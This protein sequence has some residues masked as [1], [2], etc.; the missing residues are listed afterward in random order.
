MSGLTRPSTLRAYLVAHE[1]RGD[2]RADWRPQAG[3]GVPAGPSGKRAI[4]PASDVVEGAVDLCDLRIQERGQRA[5]PLA[6]DLVDARS[7]ASPKRSDSA[8]AADHG[9]LPI[10]VDVVTGDRVGI[11]GNIREAAPD[12][13]PGI[14]RWRHVQ[15]WGVRLVRWLGEKV[16]HAAAALAVLISHF[17]PDDFPAVFV[18]GGT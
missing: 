10:N 6:E 8:G 15:V 1:R 12:E 13:I 9:S 17:G 14:D 5:D 4:V 18:V 7:E 11:P 2:R 16:A 3:A